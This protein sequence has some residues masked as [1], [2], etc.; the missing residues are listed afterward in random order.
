M[1][2]RRRVAIFDIDGTIFRSSLL[3]EVTEALIDRGIFP[4]TARRRYE[5][6]HR[7]WLDRQGS[8]DDYIMAVVETYL[9]HIKGVHFKE[10]VKT[11]QEVLRTRESRVYRYTRDLVADLKKRGYY[12]LAITLSPKGIADIFAAGLGFDKVYGLLYDVDQAGRY[13][14][15]TSENDILKSKALVLERAVLK[16]NLTLKGSVGVGDTE[17]DIK[18]LEKVDK[19]ICFNPNSELYRHAKRAGWKVV[20]ERKDV[21]YEM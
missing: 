4:S 15:K 17:S 9:T 18:F 20:V 10:F 21:I 6:Y 11:A 7:A 8:Y 12:L 14:G 19:P 13:T 2:K 1:D 16:E 5:R 3:I